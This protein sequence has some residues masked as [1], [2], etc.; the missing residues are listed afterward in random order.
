L[1]GY[2]NGKHGEHGD[3]LERREVR[4][5]ITGNGVGRGPAFQC[6]L[7]RVKKNKNL[8]GLVRVVTKLLPSKKNGTF[9][10]KS[11]VIIKRI[12]PVLGARGA[13]MVVRKIG[14]AGAAERVVI[15]M[16]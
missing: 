12:N 15:I 6:L 7:T 3:G 16:H 8:P 2:Y 1:T 10:G 4:G 5:N 13:G 9:T 11:T 14:F